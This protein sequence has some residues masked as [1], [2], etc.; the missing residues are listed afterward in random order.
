MKTAR[1]CSNCPRSDL[2]VIFLH[3]SEA[4]ILHFLTYLKTPNSKIRAG[5]YAV[6]IL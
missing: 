1:F 2:L 4:L 5:R 6:F 3:P